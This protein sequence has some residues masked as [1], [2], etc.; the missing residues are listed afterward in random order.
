MLNDNLA[1]GDSIADFR[2]STGHVTAWVGVFISTCN[3]NL[4]IVSLLTFENKT[5]FATFALLRDKHNFDLYI[6]VGQKAKIRYRN[7]QELHLT[8]DIVR[9][10][11]QYTRK[12][13]TQD[14]QEVSPFPTGGHKATW[15]R[16]DNLAKT[17]T[18]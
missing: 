12:K 4:S 15:H 2:A 10:N 13:H 14:S 3:T 7:N 9:E 8:Q 18:I 17:N 5:V 1:N 6:K 16:Q 11:D